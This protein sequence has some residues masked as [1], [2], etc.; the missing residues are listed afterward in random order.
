MLST[1]DIKKGRK[2]AI[3][4]QPFI[5]V[6]FQHNKMGRGGAKV[7]TKLKNIKTGQ[8]LEKTFNSGE[9]FEDPDFDDRKMQ[10]LYSDNEGFHFMDSET[11]EQVQLTEEQ[12]GD[13]KW[14]LK[15]STEYKIMFFEGQPINV[16]MPPSVIMEVVE[17]EPGVKGDSVSN[18]TKNAKVETGMNV[19]VPLFIKE[20]DKI[21]IDTRTGD[22]LERS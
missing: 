9:T 22:Y 19:K 16:D 2:M 21:K 12:I 11:F 5:V 7:W 6:D 13:Y 17:A 15:E 8:V 18:L 20:G 10:Y 4:G 14:Y 3:D 1:S